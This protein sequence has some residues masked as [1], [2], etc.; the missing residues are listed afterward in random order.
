MKGWDRGQGWGQG[1]GEDTPLVWDNHSNHP[2]N[3]SNSHHDILIEAKLAFPS[4][5]FPSLPSFSTLNSL[6]FTLNTK[7]I[8]ILYYFEYF[9]RYKNFLQTTVAVDIVDVDYTI[10]T[11]ST[12]STGWFAYL[13]SKYLSYCTL[14]FFRRCTFTVHLGIHFSFL[15]FTTP[16]ACPA[17][18]VTNSYCSTYN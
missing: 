1:V 10:S 4:L 12:G 7:H 17:H 14:S 13:P 18:L 8:H 16:A 15:F 6:H 3:N 5:P 11:G 9:S 2:N